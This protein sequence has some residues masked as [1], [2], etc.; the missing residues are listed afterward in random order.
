VVD[1]ACW[2]EPAPRLASAEVGNRVARKVGRYEVLDELG[3]G[4]MATVYLARQADLD[5]LVALKELS[6]LRQSDPSF[7]RRFLR[8]SQLVGSLSHP[9]IVTVHEYFEND[10]VPYIAMEYVPR[11]S[12]RPHVGDMPLAQVAGVLDGILSALDYAEQHHIV[13]RDLKPE[14]VMVTSDGRVKLTDFGI[15]KATGRAFTGSFLT[16]AGTT[17]GTPNYM[18]PEQAMGQ[19]VGP[20]TDLYSVGVMAFE[21]FVGR[22]PF[23]DT[24]EP[25]AVLM[26]QVSDSIPPVHTLRPEV[27]EAISDWIER[28]LVKEPADRV[29]SASEAWDQ[30]E[31]IVL[32]LVGALWRREARLPALPSTTG[33]LPN[34]PLTPP[35]APRQ[36]TLSG[37]STAPR[38]RT[39]SEAPTR[40]VR[41]RNGPAMAPTVMPQR[42]AQA[43]GDDGGPQQPRRTRRR[44]ALAKGALV[45]LAALVAL[46]A[47]FGKSATGP[48][49]PRASDRGG[50]SAAALAGPTSR[51][52]GRELALRVPR[53]W[54]RM[55]SSPGL[56]LPLSG[57]VAV[58]PHRR[59]GDP[60]VEFGVM[61]DHA[62]SNSALLPAD[63]LGS[64]GQPAGTVPARTAVRLPAQRLEAWR[65]RG[66]RPA[67]TEREL[68]VYAVPT[69]TGVATVA[70]AAA[71]AQAAAFAG[72]CE[73]VAGT[74]ELVS[75]RPYAVGPSATYA[76]ALN[77]TTAGLQRATSAKEATLRGA[78]TLAAQAGAARGLAGDYETAAARLAVL[79]LSPADRDANRRLV[80]ALR[81]LSRAYRTVAHAATAGDAARYRAASA[82]VPEAKARVSSALAGV[83]ATGSEPAAE[84]GPAPS[85]GSEQ[86]SAPDRSATTPERSATTPRRPATTSPADPE[87]DEE[88]DVGDSRSDDPS[89]DSEDP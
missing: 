56:G 73:A 60:L 44:G 67:A 89:D 75:G 51:V 54:S 11:G 17:V 55:P 10:G 48:R 19:A 26:R 36:R 58:G 78:R 79:D 71:R 28:L 47:A 12:L 85:S 61:K 69:T 25:M 15:A 86:G 8:E 18:A 35:T 1:G 34:A 27:D 13:H 84:K 33:Q 65:Y 16:V 70:C 63:L 38:Q 68:T 14:N 20:W 40:R 7:I 5:R 30:F 23:Q 81:R 49:G 87:D 82:A 4:G 83:R 88:D 22:A 62:A 45:L 57:A 77:A 3:R 80:T 32:A 37:R 29:Q 41:E 31:E 24:E 53:G 66:L 21:M 50:S 39:L 64:I 2:H 72:Q 52:T 59:A 46:T 76:N 9:N 43:L 42:P 74:L 6:V